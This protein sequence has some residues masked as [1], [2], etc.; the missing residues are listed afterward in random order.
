MKQHW[1]KALGVVLVCYSL[2][3]GLL[4]PLKPGIYAVSPSSSILDTTLILDVVGYN[5]HFKSAR[6]VRVWL[7]LD[8][9]FS[10]LATSVI[11]S[12]ETDLKAEFHL[13][14]YLPIPENTAIA[15]LVID[16]EVD[17][18]SVKPSAVF[19]RQVQANP[20]MGYA[21]WKKNPINELHPNPAPSFPFRGILEETIRNTYFHV[22]MWFG[23]VALFLLSLFHGIR[24]L[25]G[26][27]PYGA[28]KVY[29]L[30]MVGLLYG[31][32]GL[33]TGMLWAKFTWNAFWSMDVKQNMAAIATLIY[34]AYFLLYRALPD[35][36]KRDRVTSAYNIFA[37]TTLIPLLFIIPRMQDSLH[38]GSGGNP[39]LGGEDLDHTM[40]MVFYPAV[41]GWIIMGYWLATLV[42]RLR[43]VTTIIRFH[44]KNKS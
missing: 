15:S 39:A 5:T 42:Y 24:F 32:L 36:D 22:P 9:D 27:D 21:Y 40:R 34:L 11:P 29:A 1:W 6:D 30:N 25:R 17:G 33:L 16:T 18:P 19:L 3:A 35:K 12:S 44:Q 28:D 20:D 23:M 43:R 13:P 38:P 31:I 41:I 4:W 7:R 37:F 14:P 26:S 10:V 2:F 8:N